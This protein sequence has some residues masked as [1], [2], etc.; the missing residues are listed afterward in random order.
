MYIDVYKYP[1]SS[2]M[3]RMPLAKKEFRDT[4]RNVR[5]LEQSM[6]DAMSAAEWSE[7]LFSEMDSH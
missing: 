1:I 5:F 2:A 6:S 7:M 3:T 4:S